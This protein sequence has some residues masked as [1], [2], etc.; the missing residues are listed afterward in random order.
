MLGFASLLF[1]FWRR[2]GSKSTGRFSHVMG[3]R[4]ATPFGSGL[5][6]EDRIE[7]PLLPDQDLNHHCIEGSLQNQVLDGHRIYC[8][9]SVEPILALTHLRRNPGKLGERQTELA[10]ASVIPVPAATIFPMKTRTEGSS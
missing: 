10:G 5:K 4:P 7:D 2:V 1:P 3:F 6:F 8:A 9:D